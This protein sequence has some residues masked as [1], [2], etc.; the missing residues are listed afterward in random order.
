MFLQKKWLLT[1]MALLLALFPLSAM[2]EQT[3]PDPPRIL[4][5]GQVLYPDVPPQI[6]AGR[7]L[8]EMRAVF[9]ALEATLDWNEETRTVTAFKDDLEIIL[10]V[11]E[12]TA[13]VNG[14]PY[15]LDAPARI[16]NGRTLVP[17][18]FVSETLG[19]DVAWDGETRTVT[20]TTADAD[21]I[22]VPEI[23]PE[24]LPEEI[25]E[26]IDYSSTL[27]L[28]QTR[29]LEDNTY[30]LVTYG[31]KPTGGYHVE[32]QDVMEYEEEIR[33]TVAFTEPAEDE[34]VTQALTYPDDLYVMEATDKPVT[35]AATG[36]ESYVPELIGLDELP[37]IVAESDG[38]KIFSPAPETTVPATFTIEGISNVFEGTVQL[39]VLDA[40]GEELLS[41]FTTGAMG[42]WGYFNP[43][44]TLPDTVQPG[45]ALTLELY[46]TSAK[47]GSIQDLI[48]IPLEMDESAAFEP[49]VERDREL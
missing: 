48:E 31:E 38:I 16:K 35:F 2:A 40:D 47:D 25:E 6:E 5:D 15:T 43:F 36:A 13:T 29:T 45:D 7:T 20:I 49:T 12:L 21:P 10:P 9:E 22:S 8:V 1:L 46:T 19:A 3:E 27:W 41:D 32:I 37:P 34:I 42:D 23:E 17:A 39:R 44:L 33:V 18:R 28:G 4:V 26:W 24:T 14:E 30:I 11:D